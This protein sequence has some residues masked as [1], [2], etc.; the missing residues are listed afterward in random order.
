MHWFPLSGKLGPAGSAEH[1]G[2]EGSWGHHGPL[3]AAS[4]PGQLVPAW[5]A[6]CAMGQPCPKQAL[7]AELNLPAHPSYT[8][9]HSMIS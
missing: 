3:G 5:E 9:A 7:Y 1:W 4:G 2:R 6:A 8:P